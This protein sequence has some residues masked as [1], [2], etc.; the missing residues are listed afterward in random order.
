M[1]HLSSHLVASGLHR[2]GWAPWQ[3]GPCLSI[4]FQL[5]S[6]SMLMFPECYISKYSL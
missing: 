4:S 1:T 3:N 2:P 6:L 5:V